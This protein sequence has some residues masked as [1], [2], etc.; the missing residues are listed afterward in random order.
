[1]RTFQVL[2]LLCFTAVLAILSPV[3]DAHKVSA[4]SVVTEIDTKK[5]TCKVELAMEVEPTGDPSI[6]DLISPE[7]AA[8]TF[9]T[10]AL[11]VYF[12]DEPIDAGEPDIRT[13]DESD[14][15]TPEDL[16]R[17]KVVATVMRKIPDEAE[18]F[19]LYVDENTEAAV[20]M[21]VIKDEKPARRLQV[22][23]PGEFSNPVNVEP[24]ADG[25]P[26]SKGEK[27]SVPLPGE[28]DGDSKPA[29]SE[30]ATPETG[31]TQAD[32]DA[33]PEPVQQPPVSRIA[34]YGLVALFVI[35]AVFV[36]VFVMN[37]ATDSK[38]D[39]EL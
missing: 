24:V 5:R 9:A 29:E 12:D 30:P 8:T 22:L 23:Y 17:K 33:E 20:V 38:T 18:N 36:V 32:Q 2:R 14:E 13:I 7:Q 34:L 28:T 1:M 35:A 26:F 3:A 15:A 25:D 19:L 4:V 37:R 39:E 16:R 6:D 10:E 11:I 21:V 31:S 27:G